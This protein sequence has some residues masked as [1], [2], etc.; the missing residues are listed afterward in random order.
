[1]LWCP[2]CVVRTNRPAGIGSRSGGLHP[3][4]NERGP[5]GR[6]PP[7]GLGRRRTGTSG[8]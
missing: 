7:F 4:S 1:M 6:H 8:A 3:P 2:G 5:V